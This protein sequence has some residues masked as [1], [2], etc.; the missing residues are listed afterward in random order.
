MRITKIPREIRAVS[1]S[2]AQLKIFGNAADLLM[3]FGGERGQPLHETRSHGAEL[4]SMLDQRLIVGGDLPR[5]GL[6]G[7]QKRVTRTQRAF[8]T[9]QTRPIKRIDLAPEKIEITPARVR[10]AADEFDVGVRK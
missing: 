6:P 3:R 4:R 2:E 7:F 5:P 8:V 9:A 1:R 10:A